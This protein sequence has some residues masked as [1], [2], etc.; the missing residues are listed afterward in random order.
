MKNISIEE[1][2][3]FNTPRLS[4]QS[5][6]HQVIGLDSKKR[7][8]RRIIEILT[9][10]VTKSLPDGWQNISNIDDA[11]EWIENR[12]DESHFV[13]IQLL[14]T[15]ET[16]GFI[17]LYE[18]NSRHKY[19]NI[20][21]GYLLSEDVWGKGL[22]TELLEGLIKWCQ[23]EGDIKSLSGGVETD[24]LGSIKVLEK[25]GFTASTI[26]NRTEKVVFYEYQFD[27]K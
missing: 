15:N 22:G 14:S 12:D 17:F 23:A 25:T 2:C 6:K 5:W 13:T 11:Q 16:V 9:P 8:A 7:F 1:R 3:N 21:F 20:R 10:N 18:F 27:I 24:N 4:V 26:D 19:Y